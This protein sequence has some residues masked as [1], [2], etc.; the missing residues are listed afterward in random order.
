MIFTT[1]MAT[2]LIAVRWYST[3]NV[4]TANVELITFRRLVCEGLHAHTQL[5]GQETHRA[6]RQCDAGLPDTLQHC[7]M[8][9]CL[10]C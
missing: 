9:M 8:L 10:S 3:L 1:V 7:S 2:V 6:A 4:V 5:S